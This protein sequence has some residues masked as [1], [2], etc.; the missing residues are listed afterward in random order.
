MAITHLVNYPDIREIGFPVSGAGSNIPVGTLMMK[1][2][3]GGTN[4]GVLIPVTST[5]NT[6][7]LGLLNGPHN[8]GSS[9]DA[10]T[11]TLVQWFPIPGF[12]GGSTLLGNASVSGSLGIY[13][14]HAV[15]LFDTATCIK[16]DYDLT[17]TVT[18]V[19][20]TTTTVVVTSFEDNYDGGYIYVNAGTGIGQLFFVQASSSG[21]ITIPATPTV[22][23]DS[24][25]KLTKIQPLFLDTLVWKVNT[26]TQPTTIDSTAA[27]GT[28]RA[29]CL[30]QFINLNGLITRLD[31]KIYS[32]RTGLNSL[33][34][35]AF[36]SYLQV[37]DTALHPVT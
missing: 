9:G 4:K 36:S 1:G 29:V 25:S 11:A 34:Q 2:A 21:N 24:T 28:G 12:S 7:S 13:P 16:V 6:R 18:V 35:L 26:T 23:L 10:T 30:A 15:E 17:S 8:F 3:T 27:A 37:V 32:G 14:S 31:P 33:S 5:S 20:N 19:S 22:G